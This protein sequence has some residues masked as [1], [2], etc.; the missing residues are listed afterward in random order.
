[1]ICDSSE[2]CRELPGSCQEFPES[3][4][5]TPGCLARSSGSPQ[6]PG[7]PPRETR[8]GEPGIVRNCQRA[9]GKTF[10]ELPGPAWEL[11]GTARIWL[12]AAWEL[13]GSCRDLAGS[14]LGTAGTWLGAAWD[15]L[16]RGWELLGSCRDL[17]GSCLGPAGT[18]LGAACELPGPGWENLGKTLEELPG[19]TSKNPRAPR[20]PLGQFSFRYVCV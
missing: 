10:R 5:G 18:W 7:K 3:C 15:L 12:G 19:E 13:P 2:S 17:A 11:P 20:G 8:L 16:G 9:A 4:R 14:C 6:T 1:M